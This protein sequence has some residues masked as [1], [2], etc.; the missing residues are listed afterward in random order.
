VGECKK[1]FDDT[2]TNYLFHPDKVENISH[3]EL[4]KDLQKYK[5]AK[6][7]NQDF[8]I[9]ITNSTTL[10]NDY[11]SNPLEFLEDC[12]WNSLKILKRLK[13]RKFLI[14]GWK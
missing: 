2:D 11:N 4:I 5:L 14:F 6:R 9:W 10:N 13:K 7:P 1:T 3:D 12:N 8:K